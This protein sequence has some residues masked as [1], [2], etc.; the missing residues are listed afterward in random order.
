[1]NINLDDTTLVIASGI[2][3]I[4]IILILYGFIRM[5]HSFKFDFL[6]G[7]CGILLFVA[8]VQFIESIWRLRAIPPIDVWDIL[9]L[10]IIA[11]LWAFL[12]G[13][14]FPWDKEGYNNLSAYYFQNKKVMF[15]VAAV[16]D[17]LNGIYG[18]ISR[19]DALWD[20]KN[21]WRL[22][23]FAGLLLLAF[24]NWDDERK[25]ANHI[26]IILTMVGLPFL[27]FMTQF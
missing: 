13:I 25:K 15:S 27:Y 26:Y 8:Q 5:F 23:F 17:I 12:S 18:T 22:V 9:F 14:L 7:I 19:H 6:V 10:L 11:F 2:A 24:E 16:N 20:L 1:M 3:A 21:V 4:G